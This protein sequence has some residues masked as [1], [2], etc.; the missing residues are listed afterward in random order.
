MPVVGSMVPSVPP[1]AELR[2]H[3]AF[4]SAKPLLVAENWR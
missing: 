4:G 1:F 3:V 2:D